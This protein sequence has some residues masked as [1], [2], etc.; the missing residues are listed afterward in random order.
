MELEALGDF[1]VI[2]NDRVAVILD[3]PIRKADGTEIWNFNC[4]VVG[5]T[6]E[7]VVLEGD[8]YYS[9]SQEPVM[10]DIVAG[11][12]FMLYRQ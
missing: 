6:E 5:V 12:M 7:K 9:S 3:E 10:P 1:E 8:Y 4:R 11:T 2:R